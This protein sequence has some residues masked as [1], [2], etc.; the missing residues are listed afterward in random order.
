[1]WFIAG[2]PTKRIAGPFVLT[3]LCG[4]TS[5][6][7]NVIVPR[8]PPAHTDARVNGDT[9]ARQGDYRVEIELRDLREVLREPREPPHE[10]DERGSVGSRRS[11][12]AAH[13]AACLA[14]ENELLRIDAVSGAI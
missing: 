2:L 5:L 4:I 13:E 11:T 7:T 12:E 9:A 14:A 6:S 1:M 8:R 10:V 3:S